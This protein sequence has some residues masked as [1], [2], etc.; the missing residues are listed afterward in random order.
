M[1]TDKIKETVTANE[2]NVMIRNIRLHR[3]ESLI[4]DRITIVNQVTRE[5]NEKGK[6]GNIVS[7][8][9]LSSSTEELVFP[10]K[11]ITLEQLKKLRATSI[12]SFVLKEG[13]NYYYAQIVRDLNLVSTLLC[14]CHKC[15][16]CRY[17]SAA[18]DEE[19]GCAKVRNRSY[20]IERYDWID[21]YETFNTNRDAFVVAV[22]NHYGRYLPKKKQTAEE[23]NNLKLGL[24][25]FVWPEID[26]LGAAE[27]RYKEVHKV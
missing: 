23:V 18:T 12:P 19:G 21:G 17:L 5:L 16:A 24:A 4:A 8:E 1:T 26:S 11:R 2:T 27:K 10:M 3:R 22:C 9:E 6:S 14:G 13:G 25:Q 20:Y 15:S 7:N